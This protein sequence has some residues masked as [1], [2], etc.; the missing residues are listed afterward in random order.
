V[1]NPSSLFISR[2]S[3][4]SE[5]SEESA[6]CKR[7][8]KQHIFYRLISERVL[9]RQL[10]GFL[11]CRYGSSSSF[12]DGSG[13]SCFLPGFR[14]GRF[15]RRC[16]PRRRLCARGRLLGLRRLPN[17]QILPHLF[18]PF[19]ANSLNRQQIIHA[20]E[21]AVRLPHLEYLIRRRRPDSRH[22]LQLRRARGIQIDGM[23]WRLLLGKDSVG[24]AKNQEKQK[25]GRRE[26]VVPLQ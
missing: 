22:L 20:L 14:G 5:K 25:Q 2:P 21:R 24:T 19:R 16:L 3:A 10:P 18:Q 4:F 13:E 26:S 6:F 7:L 17:R 11:I 15:S 9:E 12:A 23:C 1:R 8:Q